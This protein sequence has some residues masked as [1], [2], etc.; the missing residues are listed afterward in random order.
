MEIAVECKANG[1]S[2]APTLLA[3]LDLHSAVVAG[4]AMLIRRTLSIQ[5]VE[6][7]CGDLWSGALHGWVLHII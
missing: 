7:G 5:K 6:A 4:Y 3:H 1:L 2:M